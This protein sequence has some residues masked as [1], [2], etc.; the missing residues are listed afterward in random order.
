MKVCFAE[1]MRKIDALAMEQFNIPGIVLMENAARSCVL[2][3]QHFESFTVICG[4][5]NNGG[6]GLAIARMLL[7]KG[8]KVSIYLVLGD[9]F[10][11]DALINYNILK[12]MG[13]EFKAAHNIY[14]LERD[15]ASSDCTV[16]AI[17][18]TGIKGEVGTP[19]KEVIEAVNRF[20]RYV[21][22]VDVPSGI[23]SDTGEVKTIAVKA[24]KTVTFAAYKAGL[25]LFPAADFS[26]EIVCSDISIPNKLLEEIEINI[27]N[28]EYIKNIM[29]ERKAN[30]HKGDYG[31]IFI[32]GGSVGMAG[33]VALCCYGAFK[34]GAGI[35]T[36]CV[37]E[38]IN[39]IVQCSCVQAMT[40]PVDFEK[41]VDKIIQKMQGYD[42]IL[43]GNGIGREEYNVDL[44]EA[45]LKS[46]K[47]PVVIDADGLYALSK[48]PEMLY[49]CISDVVITPHSM[50]MARLL[51]K[52]SRY[53][54]ENRISVS[55]EFAIKYGLTL[56][57]KGKHSIITAPCG[58]QYININGNSGMATAGSGDVL[59]GMTAGLLAV[60]TPEDAAVLSVYLHG[61]AG[62][63]AAE[64]LT[65]YSV[66]ATDI[67]NAVPHILP[68][69]KNSKV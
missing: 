22:S 54:E 15:I 39:D 58:K 57:L 32:I 49:E 1:E 26:G 8:K 13:A 10:S 62:D 43:F 36:A 60:C 69:E 67:L 19:I 20:A 25:L 9:N 34:V 3:L 18:G 28:S 5:G 53:V 59:A 63:F 37:P 23:N 50:E 41:D 30:S 55:K 48:R 45:V 14:E 47:V 17:F 35:V 21:L 31:R 52:D 68:V 44:L 65:E 64:S 66:T 7:N 27:L 51:G 61:A 16:D 2:E 33:A 40:Y 4:K 42:V 6:D 12:A 46:A 56:V 11:G 29:P 24:N 38:E